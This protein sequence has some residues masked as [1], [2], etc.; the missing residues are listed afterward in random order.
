MSDITK[1]SLNELIQNI[2]NK[3][4]SSTEI[5]NSF[6]ERSEKSKKL[7]TYVTEDFENALKQLK[8]KY[9]RGGTYLVMEGPQFSSKAE[10]DLN[11]SLNVDANCSFFCAK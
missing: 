3:K 4:L 2:R 5:T 11:R 8:I 6:I 7:N 10:S 1:L 9:Q